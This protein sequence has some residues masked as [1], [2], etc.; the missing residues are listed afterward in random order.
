MSRLTI[1]ERELDSVPIKSQSLEVIESLIEKYKAVVEQKKQEQPE[2]TAA[3][4]KNLEV[5]L[6]KSENLKK[7]IENYVN[8]IRKTFEK[9]YDLAKNG[10][11]NINKSVNNAL[12]AETIFNHLRKVLGAHNLL[13]NYVLTLHS[14]DEVLTD[15]WEKYKNNLTKVITNSRANLS[16]SQILTQAQFLNLGFVNGTNNIFPVATLPE[17]PETAVQAIIVPKKMTDE[18]FRMGEMLLPKEYDGNPA[19]LKRFLDA[20]ELFDKSVADQQALKVSFVKTRLT[21][22]ARDV[23]G[24]ETTIA[25]LI[26]RFTSAIKTPSSDD[27]ILKMQG[28]RQKG[29]ALEHAKV[30]EDLASQ[31]RRAYINEGVPLNMAEQYVIRETKKNLI[32]AVRA[33]RAKTVLDAGAFKSAEEVTAK[34]VSVAPT[35]DQVRSQLYY[36]QGRGGR[37]NQR[38][39]Y[40]NRGRRGQNGNYNRNFNQNNNYNRNRNRNYNNNNNNYNNSNYNNNNRGRRTAAFDATPENGAGPQRQELGGDY[41]Q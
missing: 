17:I 16:D 18:V 41:E 30:I 38:G 14:D 35:E 1:V 2:Y 33:D 24:A 4:D 11:D 32:G 8:N 6:T 21:E 28:A 31:L 25:E 15:E 5:F 12:S 29:T 20:L 19:K 10:A 39:H 40:S 26:Q 36:R 13:V 3:F 7:K 23:I 22:G 27:M 37:N 9:T 34:F